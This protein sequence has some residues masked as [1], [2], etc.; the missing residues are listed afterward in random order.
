ME[1]VI[2]TAFWYVG[3]DR[4]CAI[5]RSNERYYKEF[6]SWCRIQNQLIVYT[7]SIS[8]DR[9]IDI[10][11]S[12]GLLEKTIV[13]E[14]EDI[15]AVEHQLFDKMSQVEQKDSFKEFR[16]F[17]NAM[18]NNARFDY[19]W[20][21]KYW[22]LAETV[23]RKLV[24]ENMLLAWMDFGFNHLD[25]CY[26]KMEEF[27]FLWKC[28]VSMDKIHLFSLRPIEDVSSIYSLQFLFDTMLGVFHL[29]PAHLAN[30]FWKLIRKA[31][32]ALLMLDC[33]DDDQQLLLMAC[34]QEPEL[35]EV[36]ISDWFLPLKEFGASHL[37][38][39]EKKEQKKTMKGELIE[40]YRKKKQMREF[41]KRTWNMFQEQSEK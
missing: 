12:Y 17:P 29:V 14:I 1:P 3:R 32:E 37:T 8:K 40:K 4:S 13:I 18:S 10:R 6:A 31:M 39:K 25:S 5:P 36:H 2:V 9:I 33:I 21:M 16:Y 27:N 34:R 35:F 11:K 15:F 22:C 7:D 38:V 23:N 41:F 28:D 24:A 20:M 30:Q 19:A 26:P